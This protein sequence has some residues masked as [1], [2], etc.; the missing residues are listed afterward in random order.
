MCK[1][2]VILCLLVG[3]SLYKH[4]G[5][6]T[7]KKN[8]RN[9][10]TFKT[11]VV[12]GREREREML[13][14]RN[15]F[16]QYYLVLLLPRTVVFSYFLVNI[17]ARPVW[18]Y[19]LRYYVL[20]WRITWWDRPRGGTRPLSVD[21]EKRLSI[22]THLYIYIYIRPLSAVSLLRRLSIETHLCIYFDI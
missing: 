9:L 19:F 11:I 10:A 6:S 14:Y 18:K 20:F 5:K 1:P 2:R 12:T 16:I 21:R 15:T 3:L 13:E 17:S 22:E 8:P 7:G 4:G